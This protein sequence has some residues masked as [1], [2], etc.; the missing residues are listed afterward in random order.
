MRSDSIRLLLLFALTIV[1][2]SCTTQPAKPPTPLQLEGMRAKRIVVAPFNIAL[3]LPAELESS[4]QLVSD[5]LIER[6]EELE[7][8]PQPL[9]PDVGEALW[10]ASRDEV[11]RSGGVK[12]FESAARVFASMIGERTD[13]DAIII[14]SLYIQNASTNYEAARWDG[15]TQ[16][17]TFKGRARQEIEMPP[18]TTIPAASLL[19]YVLDTEGNTIH[20]K[21]TGIELLQHMEIRIQKKQGYDQR[22][23]TLKDDDP[24]IENEAGV[25]A[26]VAHALYPYLPR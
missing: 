19:I 6:L 14:P 11:I 10:T 24:P 3:P 2:A 18:A 21:R 20:S 8:N 4:T 23:W 9:E 25:R 16:R 13:F 5:A 1:L 17:I 12:N 15:T 22:V 26:A 7:K